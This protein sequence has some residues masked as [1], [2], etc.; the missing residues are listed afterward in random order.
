[1]KK[2]MISQ[3]MGGKT[4]EEI[5]KTREKAIA[6]LNANGYEVIN[7]WFNDEYDN[8]ADIEKIGIV[9]KP[10]YFL[11]KSLN[12]MSHCDAVYFCD[13]W[14]N[15]RGCV[16]EHEAATKYNIHIMYETAME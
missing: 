6:T 11:A 15:T 13:G 1:M 4:D 8:Y 7:T 12:I 2:A 14:N 5:A 9:N 16:I 10:L 3:P